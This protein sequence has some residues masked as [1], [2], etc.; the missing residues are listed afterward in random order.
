MEVASL[1]WDRERAPLG[2]GSISPE[3]FAT[4]I[5]QLGAWV[6]GTRSREKETSVSET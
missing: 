3:R 6:I 1:G 5:H 4:G 2:N